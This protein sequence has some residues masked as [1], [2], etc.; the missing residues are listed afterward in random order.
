[1]NN[2][3]ITKKCLPGVGARVRELRNRQGLSLQVT[4]TR[5]GTTPPTLVQLERYDLATTRTLNCVAR[6]LCVDVDTLTGRKGTP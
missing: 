3:R 6:A 4:A 1:M 2:K 5:G